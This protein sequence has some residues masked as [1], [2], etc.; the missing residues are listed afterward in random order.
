MSQSIR[1][2]IQLRA[3]GSGQVNSELNNIRGGLGAAERQAKDTGKSF[4]DMARQSLSLN[5]AVYTLA[6]GLGLLAAVHVAE[7]ILK[8]NRAME[9]LRAQLTAVYHDA[10]KGQQAFEY[11]KDW[12]VKTPYEIDTVTKTFLM[13]KNYGL[14]PTADV[15][16]A[17]TNQS[18]M[19]G[20]SQETLIGTTRALGQMWAKSKIQGQE[21]LQMVD[22]GI[23]IWGLLEK[24][25]GQNVPTLQAMMEKGELTRDVISKLIDEM[26]R[27]SQGANITAM[28]TMNGQISNLSDSWTQFQDALI[29]SS[30][31]N[32]I[33]KFAGDSANNLNSLR[34]H[35]NEILNT[36]GLMGSV[37][38][39]VWSGNALKSLATYTVA[40]YEA[41]TME[42]AHAA[43]I[44]INLEMAIAQ[45]RAEVLA[46]E[47]TLANT[48][49]LIANLEAQMAA[50]TSMTERLALSLPLNAAITAQT[51]ATEA[52]ALA[53]ANLTAAQ[54]ALAASSGAL[55]TGMNLVNG[56][57]AAFI[58]WKIGE[59]LTTFATVQNL[60]A[61]T[62]G[63]WATAIENLSY[64]YEYLKNLLTLNFDA[65]A[66][67][68]A[69]H[70]EQLQNIENITLSA[71]G[72]NESLANGGVAADKSAQSMAFLNDASKKA[73]DTAPALN[74]VTEMAKLDDQINKLTLSTE[75]YHQTK[76][77]SEFT[78]PAEQAA[79]AQK[80]NLVAEL[81]AKKQAENELN[82]Q[83]LQQ[84]QQLQSE[85][86]QLLDSMARENALVFDGS[87][88]AEVAYNVKNGAL[89]ALDSAQKAH[90]LT[91]AKEHDA[92]TKQLNAAEAYKQALA[93]QIQRLNEATLSE[94]QLYQAK[95]RSQ[96]LS[97]QQ[98]QTVTTAKAQADKAVT[99]KAATSSQAYQQPRQAQQT[100]QQQGNTV[101]SD[102][103]AAGQRYLTDTTAQLVQLNQVQVNNY[104]NWA[105]EQADIAL[106]AIYGKYKQVNEDI[107][108]TAQR[109]ADQTKAVMA[110]GKRASDDMANSIVKAA[111]GLQSFTSAV[112]IFNDKF[113][114]E[115][116]KS[117]INNQALVNSLAAVNAKLPAT[118]EGYRK[119]VEGLNIANAAEAKRY[120][121]L[122]SVS[123]A[124][125]AYYSALE[126]VT[127]SVGTAAVSIADANKVIADS[128]A[129]AKG[130]LLTAYK[131]EQS[132]LDGT[133]K[134]MADFGAGIKKFRD[135]LVLGNLSD[136][137][138]KDKYSEAA[139]QFNDAL[140]TI[141]AGAGSTAESQAKYE[142]ALGDL[143]GKS[144]AFLEASR[145]MNASGS[146][147]SA[148]LKKVFAALGSTTAKT[149]ATKA[150]AQQQL[151]NL[152]SVVGGLI[153]INTQTL[154]VKQAID[155]LN[156]A[157]A[158]QNAAIVMA[159]NG[160]ATAAAKMVTPQ[161]IA[162]SP[163]PAVTAATSGAMGYSGYQSASV[164]G[165]DTGSGGGYG[166]SSQ[167]TQNATAAPYVGIRPTAGY[168]QQ[169]EAN[170]TATGY[171]GVSAE[172][173]AYNKATGNASAP[174]G[175]GLGSG[176]YSMQGSGSTSDAYLAVAAR[177]KAANGGVAIT[178]DFGAAGANKATADAAAA[179][180]PGGGA[181]AGSA[182]VNTGLSSLYT[183][184]ELDAQGQ[185]VKRDAAGHKIF[186]YM[187][188]VWAYQDTNGAIVTTTSPV[189][190][191]ATGLE[192]VTE[193]SR[194]VQVHRDEMIPT[195]EAS[196]QLRDVGFSAK[197]G[198]PSN[199]GASGDTKRLE[200]LLK[201]LLE[202]M[203]AGNQAMVASIIESGN[204]IVQSNKQKTSLA[205]QPEVV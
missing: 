75:A 125:D 81:T 131:A 73:L 155:A 96:G 150:E 200:E 137:S 84:G 138:N 72:F 9:T 187:P 55:F 186:E 190:G 204:A 93:E 4:G 168:T 191:Y 145:V 53:S 48:V 185:P 126:K 17:L 133:I 148:D 181:Q 30:G 195:A 38:I 174:T 59:Y 42:R 198:F 10:A 146:A 80:L 79:Y 109:V 87:K 34:G 157:N 172:N 106:T 189:K 94:N 178:T 107:G 63:N 147:Y 127:G 182:A 67:L 114:P 110:Q 104:G 82:K 102:M 47:T 202:I 176:G 105:K 136:K 134:R 66:A 123:T 173:V 19:L 164:G 108:A 27:A 97:N 165:G 111:G 23:P 52:A 33:A 161:P 99:A 139:A 35:I 24:A 171:A 6:G 188:G 196:K 194:I 26:A 54:G 25:T 100:Q 78:N 90:L 144:T 18:S 140:S 83:A 15:M 37:L 128:I 103:V 13:L 130:D 162:S 119:L 68:S 167:S 8:T 149:I 85:Y 117:A 156:T 135:S 113:Y 58:G 159:I 21:V 121:V 76:A 124:A 22:Q 60:M 151:I 7:E 179:F 192:R 112:L 116:Q 64:R 163:A 36:A 77:K 205:R 32:A 132:S 184:Q 160:Q 62:T 142:A 50:T 56:A 29:N 122:I 153:D 143:Q 203:G 65:N 12:A 31:E 92:N 98:I 2:G 91:L 57:M 170:V 16:G 28:A 86:Q 175:A 129:K 201:Q 180:Q 69:Q 61:I 197:T 115:T 101:F 166:G 51:A 45:A 20:G 88:A 183:P 120:G 43:A 40:K 71:I 152:D 154:T 169:Q 177:Q 1:L 95:L 89:S 74:F 141:N 39:T 44:Q 118:R 11:I 41:V 14:N 3:D 199:G 70:Q 49:A 46:T 193:E 158:Q 5:N